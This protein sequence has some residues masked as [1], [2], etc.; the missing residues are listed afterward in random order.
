MSKI[1][2][3]YFVVCKFCGEQ[4]YSTEIILHNIE[5]NERGEDVVTYYCPNTGEETKSLVHREA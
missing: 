4:H 2:Y 5:E 1:K 3:K